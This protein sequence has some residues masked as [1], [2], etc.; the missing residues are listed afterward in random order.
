MKKCWIL[1]LALGCMMSYCSKTDTDSLYDSSKQYNPNPAISS[2]NPTDSALSGAV[3]IILNGQ[4]FSTIK[5]NN[6]VYFG[7]T[8]CTI[9]SAS[10]NELI[11]QSP[12]ITGD[13]LTLQ[14]AVLGALNFSNMVKYKLLPTV[15]KIGLFSSQSE[16]Y[17]ITCDKN[18]NLYILNGFSKNIQK[19]TPDGQTIDL[20][21]LSMG[22]STCMQVG[23][24]DFL[25]AVRGTKIISR[26]PLAGGKDV[27]WI[28]APITIN[29]FDFGDQ[30]QMYAGG[31]ADDLYVITKEGVASIAAEYKSITINAVRVCNGYVYVVGLDRTTSKQTVWRNRIESAT[32]LAAREAFFDWSTSIGTIYSIISMTADIDGT[33]YLGTDD[34]K[35]VYIVRTDQTFGPLYE[36]MFTP[37]TYD[38]AWGTENFLY[39]CRRG[40]DPS[41]HA[42]LKA[43]MQKKGAP[44]Y[45]RN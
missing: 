45:G 26:I 7:K 14:V 37:S 40:A 27:K 39:I 1:L 23:P 15:I 13:S 38:M 30:Q 16:F 21:A 31:K 43:N 33:I 36:G 9:L 29:A 8:K 18:E 17:S 3:P 4:N 24:G 11:F 41:Y 44:Y 6:F 22:S 34:P 12:T 28:T 25:Y 2:V 32:Q 20:P 19:V 5:D 35:S 42:I 10:A